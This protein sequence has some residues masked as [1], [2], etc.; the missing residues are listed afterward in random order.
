MKKLHPRVRALKLA[1]EVRERL[2]DALGQ[3][4]NV[5][6]FGSQA[7][8]D[9]TKD[10]DID[11]LVILPTMNPATRKLVSDIAW[12]VGFDADKVIS[13]FPTTKQQMDYYAI[14]PFYHNVRKEGVA[15]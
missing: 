8:G 3:P 4:V 14:L 12:E 2:T 9:A 11:L 7:R 10:S 5:I 13:T 6:M 15:V 1:A